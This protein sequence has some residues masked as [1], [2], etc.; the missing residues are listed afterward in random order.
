M[1]WL[2]NSSIGRKVVMSVTG[3]ALVLFLLFHGS[4]NLVAV[5]SEEGYNMI[6]EFLGANWYAL[7][8]TVGL[9]ALMIIHI[10]YASILT[11]QNYKARGNDR[12][13]VTGT[14]KEVEWA[15]Q[16]MFI[17]GLIVVLGIG[18]H[19]YNFWANMQ[20][21][22]LMGEHAVDAARAADGIYWIK[23][24]FSNPVYS[25]L[26]LVWFVA[27][28]F[29]LSHGV[30]SMMHSM[31]WNNDTWMPRLRVISTV[32]ATIILAMFTVV[33]VYFTFLA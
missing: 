24:T 28:W 16:N 1:T 13:A 30:W 32:A 12:Y 18:L 10:I 17:L 25:A 31:G 8:A 9:A 2:S 5:F 19:L 26:Y 27:I 14:P 29:H 4:M 33:L 21:V 23:Q 6:C 20:L 7:V 11:L 3:L 22:E 15:S